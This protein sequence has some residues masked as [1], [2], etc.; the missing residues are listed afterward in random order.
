MRRASENRARA[1]R[2]AR[3]RSLVKRLIYDHVWMPLWK[4]MLCNKQVPKRDLRRKMRDALWAEWRRKPFDSG[5]SSLA[6]P[7]NSSRL[8]H[9]DRW[10]LRLRTTQIVPL[11]V[12]TIAQANH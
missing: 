7:S 5:E 12:P 1:P 10:L 9:R 3:W 6:P 2:V 8:S 11:I 4:Q